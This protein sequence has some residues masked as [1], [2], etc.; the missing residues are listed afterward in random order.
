MCVASDGGFP[1]CEVRKSENLPAGPVW[2]R[3]VS[4]RLRGC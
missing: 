1:V 3:R 4:G 2:G